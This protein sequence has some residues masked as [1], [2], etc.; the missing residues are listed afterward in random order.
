MKCKKMGEKRIYEVWCHHFPFSQC[1]P[2][3][4]VIYFSLLECRDF[5]YDKRDKRYKITVE[6]IRGKK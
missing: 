4:D 5:W 1:E 6:R 3:D 2:W